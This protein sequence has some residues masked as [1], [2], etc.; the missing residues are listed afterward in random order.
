MAPGRICVFGLGLATSAEVAG[1]SPSPVIVIAWPFCSTATTFFDDASVTTAALQLVVV[2]E[3]LERI[4][5]ARVHLLQVGRQVDV[6]LGAAI[7]LAPLVVED[8][9]AQGPVGQGLLA[10]V[11]REPDVE[12]A[13]VG[14]GT[15]LVED[16]LPGLLG[17]V[18]GVH[19]HLGGRAV[20]QHLLQ[21]RVV[22]LGGDEAVLE[23]AV[24]DVALADRRPLRD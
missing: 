8:A 17:H 21:R 22:L 9:L 10:G 7:D 16:H 11:E 6:V 23:H 19:R 12:A 13:G 18:L 2:R 15:V 14:L 3:V 5:D 4:G 20:A 1:F 24:D